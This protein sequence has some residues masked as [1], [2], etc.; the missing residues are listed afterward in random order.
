MSRRVLIGLMALAGLAASL[1][2]GAAAQEV[3]AEVRTWAGETWRLVRPSLEVFYTIVSK[4]K[5]GAGAPAVPGASSGPSAGTP[6]SGLMPPLSP[7]AD[8]EPQP[9]QGHAE[10]DVVT[11]RQGEVEVRVPL[12]RIA[13]LLFFRHPMLKSA[14]PPYVAPTHFRYSATL[15]LVDGS[16]VEGDYVNLGTTLLRG[17]TPQ[18]R[19]EIPWE[20]IELVRFIR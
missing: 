9:K 6:P 19:V 12:A 1:P 10:R 2:R 7:A 11:L 20:E 3:T 15:V 8:K 4:T 13:S 17:M 16:R 14:L 18:G 5:E